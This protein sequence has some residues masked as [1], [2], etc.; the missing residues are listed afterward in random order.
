M[1]PER[2]TCF[3]MSPLHWMTLKKQF[4]LKVPI[5]VFSPEDKVCLMIMKTTYSGG[6]KTNL[7]VPNP[8]K[9]NCIKLSNQKLC[10]LGRI[11][12]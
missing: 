10:L 3:L 5:Q 2:A 4:Y 12:S 1:A 7:Q 11:L 6:I 8:R 9:I